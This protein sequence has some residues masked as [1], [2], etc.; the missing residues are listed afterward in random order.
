MQIDYEHDI[1]YFQEAVRRDRKSATLRN[2]LGLAKLQLGQTEQARVDFEKAAKLNPKYPDAFNN[3]GAVYFM[4]NKPGSAAKYFKKAV[5]LDETRAT[6]HVNLGSA[7][8]NQKKFDRAI[9]EYARA[10]EL[11]P[12]VLE[13]HARGGVTAQVAHPEEQAKYYYL[14]AKIYAK[15]GDVEGCLRCLRKAKEGG[16]RDL[17]NVYKEEE[18]NRLWNDARLAQVVPPPEPK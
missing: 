11:D 5:A 17:A 12:G 1:Q 18:F 4:Q 16:Y 9:N 13:R 14:L 10:L 3:V 2:K 15:R 7:W 8:F 6:F